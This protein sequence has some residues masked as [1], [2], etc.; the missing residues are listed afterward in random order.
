MVI[1]I[2]AMGAA[3]ALVVDRVVP[4]W[5]EA[6]PDEEI[7]YAPSLPEW[8]RLE[9]LA[10]RGRWAEVW[11]GIPG[12]LVASWR[13]AGATAL[14]ALT[15][16]CWLA[17]A[18]QAIQSRGGD[19]RRWAPAAGMALG[20]VSIW[21]TVFFILLQETGWGLEESH[22]VAGGIR[23]FVLGVGLREE[24]AKF[25][26]FLPLLPLVVRERDELAALIVAGCV[27]LGFGMEENVNYI[28]GSAGTETVGRM[29]SSVPFHMATTGLVGL[30]AYRA[31][32]WPREWGPQLAAIFGVMALIHGLYDAFLVVPALKPYGVA[33]S[34]ISLLLTYQFFHELRG[35]RERRNETVSLTANFLFCV[36]M[37]T[38]ATFVYLAA[39][40]GWRAAADVMARDVL[41]GAMMAY[42]FL[43][44]M[45][46]T[47]V[48]V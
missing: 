3:T 17:F 9:E 22:D 33:A 14:A 39:A 45:P 41:T 5:V 37:V 36:S 13:H 34:V 21:F 8:S 16:A 10:K 44:E 29:L 27:G 7:E 2:L 43:R 31:C 40:M 48:T 47:M 42:V 32:R 4:A 18:M 24:L 38:A 28:V 46:E 12:M 6:K 23:Y 15:G 30:A 11:I 35:L 26:C 20:V 25:I 1:G 19:I